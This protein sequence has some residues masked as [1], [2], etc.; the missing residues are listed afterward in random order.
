MGEIN[1]KNIYIDHICLYAIDDDIFLLS[2][3][4]F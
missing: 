1:F 4:F 3:S 2:F